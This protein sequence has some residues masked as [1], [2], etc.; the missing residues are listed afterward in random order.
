MPNLDASMS[1]AKDYFECF[2]AKP[3]NIYRFKRQSYKSMTLKP[4]G[5]WDLPY[6][7]ENI[8]TG[9]YDW[10]EYKGTTWATFCNKNL[11]EISKYVSAFSN[12]EG[13]YL[14]IGVRESRS[15]GERPQLDAGID[16]RLRNGLK[17]W[18]EDVVPNLVKPKL[19]KLNIQ[20]LAT[21]AQESNGVVIIHIPGSWEAPHQARDGR[22]YGKC[23]SKNY[24]LSTQQILDIAN[25]RKNRF[26]N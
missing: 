2:E 1:R 7:T 15:G 22:F 9:E 26:L 18:L 19:S 14:I 16:F 24:F 12:Y 5:T 13:G 25:R 21:D 8:F 4:I 10:V 20:T 6:L 23:G 11:E 17:S 3:Q